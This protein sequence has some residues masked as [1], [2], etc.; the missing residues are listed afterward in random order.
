MEAAKYD[1]K[2]VE[3]FIP[4]RFPFL[5]I[6]EVLE[7]TETRIVCTYH[8][9]GDEFFFQGHYPG[10][11]IVPGVIL[12]ESA[13][14]AG[15]VFLSKAFQDTGEGGSKMPVV[16]RMNEVKFKNIVRPGNTI[17]LEVSLKE[18]MGSAWFMNAKILNEGKTVL[19]FEFACTETARP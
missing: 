16:G 6:D 14:Q 7:W 4:H 5:F 3:G 10:S 17:R 1:R 2:A 11:P 13:M 18:K 8:F 19:T 12:C 9:K 15:A